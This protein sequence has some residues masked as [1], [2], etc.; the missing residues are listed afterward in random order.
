[1]LLLQALCRELTARDLGLLVV[2]TNPLTR[3]SE[4]W[5]LVAEEAASGGQGRQRPRAL[6]L[7]L[8]TAETALGGDSED[9]DDDEEE[10]DAT[11]AAESR[12][13]Y[14]GC[15]GMSGGGNTSGGGAVTATR[16]AG[17]AAASGASVTMASA[18]GAEDLDMERAAVAASLDAMPLGMYDPMAH[19]SGF[20]ELEPLPPRAPALSE[21]GSAAGARGSWGQPASARQGMSTRGPV[22]QHPAMPSPLPQQKQGRQGRGWQP[23]C[24]AKF[25]TAPPPPPPQQQ[26]Q[27]RYSRQ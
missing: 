4:R 10:T 13:C 2:A 7:R 5:L 16:A 22:G 20:F 14:D 18:G 8:A 19:H 15:C 21:Y 6:L 27:S 26:Q 11:D 23:P 25:R 3:L 17:T 9:D 1:R 24:H 12:V